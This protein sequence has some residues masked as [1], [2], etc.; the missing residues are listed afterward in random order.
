M[1]CQS[2]TVHICT[3]TSYNEIKVM[4]LILLLSWLQLDMLVIEVTESNQITIVYYCESRIRLLIQIFYCNRSLIS[5]PV[6]CRV[7]EMKYICLYMS[8]TVKKLSNFLSVISLS[9]TFTLHRMQFYNI[10]VCRAMLMFPFIMFTVY[11]Q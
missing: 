1:I 5:V 11:L 7:Y 8:S 2:V 4:L 10:L 6:H 9:M 3:H